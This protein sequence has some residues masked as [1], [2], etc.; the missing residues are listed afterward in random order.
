MSRELQEYKRVMANL[1]QSRLK[2]SPMFANNTDFIPS[3]EPADSISLEPRKKK[4]K[5]KKPVATKAVTKKIKKPNKKTKKK[6]MP[7]TSF[8]NKAAKKDGYPRTVTFTHA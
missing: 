3:R 6:A 7:N 4:K 8:F 2:N 1:R 5:I